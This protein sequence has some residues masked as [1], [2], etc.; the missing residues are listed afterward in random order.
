MME[1]AN[2]NGRDLREDGGLS[3]E[4]VIGKHLT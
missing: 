1:N 3:G 2:Q 4:F